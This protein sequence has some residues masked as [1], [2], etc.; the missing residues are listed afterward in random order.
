MFQIAYITH[1]TCL[2]HDNG[3]GHPESPE[4][5]RAVDQYIQDCG[6]SQQLTHFDAPNV[7]QE[8][9]LRVHSPAY[10]DMI[11]QNRPASEKSTFYLDSDTRLSYHSIEAAHRAAGAVILATDLVLQKKVNNAFCAVRPPGHHAKVNNAMGFCIYNNIMV[12]IAHALEFHGLERVALLDFDVHHGNGSENIIGKDERILFCSS[13]QHPFYPA[14]PFA[15]N[16]HIVSTPLSAGSGGVEFRKVVQE[17]WLVA[18]EQ[19][20]P[21]MIFISAGFDAHTDD[22]LA[23]LNFTES[24]YQW[25]T[26]QIVAVAN[27][28]SEGRIVSSLEGG[29]Q[30]DAL[31]R[32]VEAHL[33]ALLR[34]KKTACQ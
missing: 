6:L 18:L 9:L 7:T 3:L 32:S 23:N 34:T 29:Y 12:S 17:K 26:E 28:Y 10:L 16:A 14:E 25:V 21:Q 13:F 31:A 15:N 19:F 24:D 20:K 27:K 30:V 1:S 11:E 33:E 22:F 4:R 5:L 2:K 8:Q